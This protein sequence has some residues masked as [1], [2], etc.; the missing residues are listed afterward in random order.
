MMINHRPEDIVRSLLFMIANNI[1]QI[2]YLNAKLCNVKRIY[3][4]GG[5][6]QENPYIWGRFSYAVD[7]WSKVISVFSNSN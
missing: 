7:F 4:A 2:G 6:L 1:G 5:F 3:F